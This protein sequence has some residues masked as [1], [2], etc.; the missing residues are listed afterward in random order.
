MR[1]L[2][3]RGQPVEMLFEQIRILHTYVEHHL[4]LFCEGCNFGGW[5]GEAPAWPCQTASLVYTKKEITDVLEAVELANRWSRQRWLCT[6][7]H[8]QREPR[9]AFEWWGGYDHFIADKVFP[10]IPIGTKNVT[11]RFVKD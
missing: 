7:P 2:N 11:Y 1:T 5:E 8:R 3:H 4:E 9:N 6:A 10:K